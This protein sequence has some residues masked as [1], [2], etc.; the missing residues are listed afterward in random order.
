MMEDKS[1]YRQFGHI[2]EFPPEC[3]SLHYSN[4]ESF[5]IAQILFHACDRLPDLP[6]SKQHVNAGRA[7]HAIMTAVRLPTFATSAPDVFDIHV[8]DRRG[9]GLGRRRQSLKLGTVKPK[10][11]RY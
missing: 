8:E 7:A 3:L 10:T 1:N 11:A 9:C 6:R 4:P 5:G 2:F